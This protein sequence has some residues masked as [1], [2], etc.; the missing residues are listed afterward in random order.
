MK[1][2]KILAILCLVSACANSRAYEASN[3]NAGRNV[4]A[5]G[6]AVGAGAATLYGLLGLAV[7]ASAINSIDD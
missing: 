2:V 7:F 6:V 4:A 3:P 1:A 5:T